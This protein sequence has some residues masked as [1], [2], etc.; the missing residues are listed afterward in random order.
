MKTFN[1]EN[2]G[3]NCEERQQKPKQKN[4]RQ[5]RSAKKFVNEERRSKKSEEKKVKEKEEKRPKKSEEKKAS[6]GYTSTALTCLP[7]S[8]LRGRE[9]C[10]QDGP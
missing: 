10:R 2:N 7:R 6:E 5:A 1:A 4:K 3:R 9:T 8:R